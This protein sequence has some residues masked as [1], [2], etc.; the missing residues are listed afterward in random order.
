[1]VRLQRPRLMGQ[2]KYLVIWTCWVGF[3]RMINH[4]FRIGYTYDYGLSKLYS[5]TIGSHELM[6]IWQKKRRSVARNPRYF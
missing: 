4:Q 6:L 2:S 3:L 1:M 5:Y